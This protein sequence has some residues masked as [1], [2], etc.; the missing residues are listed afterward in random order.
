MTIDSNSAIIDDAR[1]VLAGSLNFIIVIAV[2]MGVISVLT[3]ITSTAII[4]VART[5]SKC[6]HKNECGRQYHNTSPVYDTIDTD[7]D[8]TVS[9]TNISVTNPV[10]LERHT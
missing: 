9:H 4:A 3:L 7:A 1:G 2:G 10:V 6:R 5:Y 8:A